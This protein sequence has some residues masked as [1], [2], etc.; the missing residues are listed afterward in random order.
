MF[1]FSI[2]MIYNINQEE[3]MGCDVDYYLD[4]DLINLNAQ[5]F[6]EEFKKRVAPLEAKQYIYILETDMVL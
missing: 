1:D 5:E 6:L 4:H 3:Q 2:N